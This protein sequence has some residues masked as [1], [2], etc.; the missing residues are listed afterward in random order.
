ME[1]RPVF[2][3]RGTRSPIYP[4]EGSVSGNGHNAEPAGPAPLSVIAPTRN[5]ADNIAPLVARLEH[6][7][8][9]GSE[10][11]FVDDSDDETPAMVES[12]ALRSRYPI[13]LIHRPPGQRAGG[14]GG[15]VVAGLRAARSAW[16]CVMDADLQHPPELIPRLLAQARLTQAD[17]VIASRYCDEGKAEGL[18]GFRTAISR[19]STTAAR[20][21]FPRRLRRVSDPMSG[22]FLLRKDLIDLDALRP[23]GFKILLEILVRNPRLKVSE[24]GFAFGK[25]HAGE[26]KASLREGFRYL[27]HLGTLR[28]G[29]DALRF[30][31][32]A[33]IGLS[34]L[35]VNTLVLLAGTELVG[36]HYLL[37]VVFATWASTLW[38]FSLTDTWVFGDR[39]QANRWGERL[40]M[41]AFVNTLA[42]LVRGPMIYVLTSLVGVYYVLS[43]IISLVALSLL[44][45]G[46]S[47]AWIWKVT[48][49]PRARGPYGYD[50]HGIVTVW[51]EAWLPELERF[52]TAEPIERPTIRVRIGG[53]RSP[54]RLGR[55]GMVSATPDGRRFFYDDGLGP[56]GF[57]IDVTMG[58][59]VE[60]IASPF[61]RRSPHV[62]YTNVVEPILRW[63]F[64]SKGYALVHGACIAFGDEAYLV[65]A[66]TDTGK[67]TTILRV[68][69]RQRRATDTGAFLSDDLT[70]LGP[71]GRVLC[72]PKPMTISRH[73]VAAVNTPVLSRRQRLGLWVQS[74]LHS[75]EGRRFALLLARTR[76]PVAT[77]NAVVQWIV[78][79]PKYHIQ[80]LVPRAK[81]AREARLAGMFVIE[82]GSQDEV[83]LDD[84]QALDTLLSNSD[85]AYGFPPYPAIRHYLYRLDGHD[86]RPIEEQI[87]AQ[88]LSGVPAR[89]LRS[90]T[91]DW[92]QRIP[93][94][95]NLRDARP[96]V[97]QPAPPVVAT[98][99]SAT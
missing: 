54:G 79:P 67:T 11:I 49:Q 5:E 83:L 90:S 38:N 8:P 99:A 72:Y 98:G 26:S 9:D 7:L 88:A 42:L 85:D 68:L 69:D 87:V 46:M 63:T 81:C 33:A 58:E 23:R 32:F 84:R 34:G 3:H 16:A 10:I 61:L 52:L 43:N 22:F 66:R 28:L 24:V 35:V 94:L 4:P 1:H 39:R 82:R 75:R 89:L 55:A 56:L 76:L 64:V 45:Y 74:R 71:D 27:A 40:V 29:E 41:F 44:R 20:L 59:T 36:F 60:V 48:R 57:W 73:T 93:T 18:D 62:L 6:V 47:D 50:I 65:T 86:L 14:L 78:P 19:T 77:I 91:M 31:A 96:P 80:Q 95:V 13:R 15:A 30:S 70:L 2:E 53:L 37:S 12:V 25:R 92:W 51:S 17:L 21:A 97:E